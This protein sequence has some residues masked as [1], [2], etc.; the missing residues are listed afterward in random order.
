MA[1]IANTAPVAFGALGTP[2]KVLA[3][4]SGL[5]EM[6][7]RSNGWTSVA[8]LFIIVPAWMVCTMSG[9][10]GLK[11]VWPAVLVCGGSFAAVQFY[12]ANYM[13]SGL[14]GRCGGIGVISFTDAVRQVW[15]PR[16]V[17]RFDDEAAVSSS[18]ETKADPVDSRWEVFSAWFPWALLSVCV[19]VWGLQDVKTFFDKH[20][21]VKFAVPRSRPAGAAKR[22]SGH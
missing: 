5:D 8:V 20:T 6:L 11:G 15:K 7:L 3:D 22:R 16:D 19:F 17:W 1:L 4:T 21:T 12:T 13:G 2:I 9:W 14:V 18:V 10:Q